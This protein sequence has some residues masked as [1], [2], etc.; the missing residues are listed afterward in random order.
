ME[1]GISL[2]YAGF[3]CYV[4][5]RVDVHLFIYVLCMCYML[6]RGEVHLCVMCYVT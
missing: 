6:E 3:M 2:I 4:L 5:G 1:Y